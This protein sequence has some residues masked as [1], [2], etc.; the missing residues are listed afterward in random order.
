MLF[1]KNL[2]YFKHKKGQLE[3]Q[4]LRPQV[5]VCFRRRIKSSKQR[6]TLL[7]V[8]EHNSRKKKN[9]DAHM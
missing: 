9:I 2:E 8:D 6:G 7:K 3:K 4:E 5:E 1:K